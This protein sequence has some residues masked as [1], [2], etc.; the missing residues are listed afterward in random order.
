MRG[1]QKILLYEEDVIENTSVLAPGCYNMCHKFYSAFSIPKLL[2]YFIPLEVELEVAVHLAH[3][4]SVPS[5][6]HRRL[7]WMRAVK[8][9]RCSPS[10]RP[11][12]R[13]EWGNW[14]PTQPPLGVQRATTARWWSFGRSWSPPSTC[15]GNRVSSPGRRSRES[16]ARS[17]NTFACANLVGNSA[18][19]R[20]DWSSH[21]HGRHL[22]HSNRTGWKREGVE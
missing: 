2:D 3:P 6:V 13:T 4:A 9:H 11:S 14:R 5:P 16:T 1:N 22:L 20:S 18:G 21:S 12:V 17:S 8:S 10:N 7:I 15:S 19:E